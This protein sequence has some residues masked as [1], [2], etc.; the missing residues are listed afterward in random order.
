MG[1]SFSIRGT[2]EGADSFGRSDAVRSLNSLISIGTV[3][4]NDSFQTFGT[5][6]AY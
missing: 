5:L 3:L 6:V 1:D 2:V 4:I